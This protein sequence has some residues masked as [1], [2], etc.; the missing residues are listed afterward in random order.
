MS[1]RARRGNYTLLFV[2]SG[3]VLVAMLALSID[4]GRLRAARVSV[5]NAAEAAAIAALMEIR[6]GRDRARAFQTA[7]NAANF[8]GE[9]AM[10]GGIGPKQFDVDIRWGEWRWQN[11]VGSRW[12]NTPNGSQGVSITVT[13]S[14]GGIQTLFGPATQALN[15]GNT[16][17]GGRVT[18]RA[19]ARAALR[20]RD[21]V[22]LFDVS[23]LGTENYRIADV[24]E[25]LLD[26]LDVLDAQRVPGDRI[27]LVAYAGDSWR[28]DLVSPADLIGF[29]T[30]TGSVVDGLAAVEP[31]LD[32]SL[33]NVRTTFPSIAQTVA[34]TQ[35]CWMGPETY[36]RAYRFFDDS[37]ID[38]ELGFLGVADA[39]RYRVLDYG[40][41]GVAV[42]NQSIQYSDPTL[43]SILVNLGG[44]LIDQSQ[45]N[46]GN[47]QPGPVQCQ[48]WT[49]G[50]IHYMLNDPR[51]RDGV[52]QGG[53]GSR[54]PL[55]CWAG[56]EVV[57]TPE[58]SNVNVNAAA[59][60]EA[61]CGTIGVND[62]LGR[63]YPFWSFDDPFGDNP[64][65]GEPDAD[66]PDFL[67]T[68]AGS[69][70]G[71]ALETA[72]D[73][74]ESRVDDSREPHVYLI[75]STSFQCGPNVSAIQNGFLCEGAFF[76][77]A[78]AASQRLNELD[79]NVFV[80]SGMNG[81]EPLFA[82]SDFVYS[83]LVSGRGFYALAPEP[84]ALSELLQEFARD[85]KIQVVE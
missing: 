41:G 15:S 80:V 59:V 48:V 16:V 85:V 47:P 50:L 12:F 8:V 46:S 36:H 40:A 21:I 6:D 52:Q 30:S 55:P 77:Q 23:R 25:A 49:F 60:P 17:N 24:R 58:V 57:L 45:W 73:I 76:G 43:Q 37:F 7:Q 68:W 54:S 56:N 5:E 39:L 38:F 35:A 61:A 22:V 13:T 62:W 42:P 19:G 72:A 66:Y 32:A 29:E 64:G 9:R 78:A 20:D 63:Q 67:Y 3:G 81:A 79:A 51:T 31:P 71:A 74:L 14:G 4:G 44:N 83:G 34:R 65:V 18:V 70:A 53:D 75:A 1:R 28:Y 2:L 33:F 11:P 82:E 84:S 69:N 26:M 10:A 27:S